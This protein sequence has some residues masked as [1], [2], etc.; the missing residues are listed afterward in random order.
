MPTLISV[1]S[2]YARLSDDDQ[3]KFKRIVLGRVVKSTTLNDAAAELRF[4]DGLVC[5]KC[6]CVHVVRNGHDRKGNQRYRCLDC[7]ATF[8]ATSN[9]I[10]SDTHKSYDTRARFIDCMMDGL[11][12]RKTAKKCKIHRNTAFLWRHK[13]LDALREME[14]DVVLDGIVEADETFFHVSYKGNHNHGAGSFSMPRPAH[15]RGHGV[16]KRGLSKEQV[17]VPCAVNRDK[18]SIAVVAK[19]GVLSKKAIHAVYDGKIDKDA[20]M[21]TD[22]LR[23]YSLYCHET[24]NEII[25]IKGGKSKKG[26]YHIQHVNSYHS[27][28]DEFLDGFHGVSTNYLNNYLV[29]NNVCNYCKGDDT[30]KSDMILSYILQCPASIRCRTIVDRPVIPS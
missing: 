21:V 13:I 24:G 28:L 15:K 14:D 16:H 30:R 3:E 4:K 7:N 9:N 11:S 10:V 25:T 2:D 12:V 26:I 23:P 19:L 18:K 29:W 8:S 6:G 20:V 27:Q 5:P 1:M 22:G 17:C